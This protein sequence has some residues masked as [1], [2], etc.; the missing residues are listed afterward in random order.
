[1]MK[2]SKDLSCKKEGCGEPSSLCPEE[3]W[4]IVDEIMI[5]IIIIIG[6]HKRKLLVTQPQNNNIFPT[7]C[8]KNR[9]KSYDHFG[10]K[11]CG[12]FPCI[13]VARMSSV[14]NS[15]EMRYL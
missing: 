5:I 10:T 11:L 6:C 13:V 3:T 9:R 7:S 8:G 1:M 15:A 12:H 2:N 4:H 14:G